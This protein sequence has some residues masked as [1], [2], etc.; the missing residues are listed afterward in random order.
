[1]T[2]QRCRI[3]LT[4]LLAIACALFAGCLTS[5]HPWV[6]NRKTLGTI[7]KTRTAYGSECRYVNTAGQLQ[8]VEKRG[9]DDALMP[10]ASVTKFSYAPGGELVEKLHCDASGSVSTCEE[11][12]AVKKYSYS[13]SVT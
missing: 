4:A 3:P 8:R 7:L 9:P 12:H 1:M 11:G 2:G 13:V 5:R 6:E 10:G